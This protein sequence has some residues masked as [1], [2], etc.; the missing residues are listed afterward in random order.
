VSV[1][2]T[3][4]TARRVLIGL[5]HDPRTIALLLVVPS[6]L[7]AI[8]RYTF[9]DTTGLFGR[10][11]P[12]MLGLFPLITMFLVTSIT[13]LRERTS[14]TLERLMTM[15]MGRL[16]LIAGYA[17]AFALCTVAQVALVSTVAAGFLGLHVEGSLAG[18]AALALANAILGVGMGLLV[19]AFATSEFQA[20]QFMPAVVF[21]QLLLCGL[22]APRNGMA[23]LLRWVSDALPLSYAYDAL[24]R[25]AAGTVDRDLGVDIAVTVGAALL[26]VSLAAATIRRRTD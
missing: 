16:D 1:R 9:S 11:A 18:V 15:P 3:S 14:G 7:L 5:R 20:V 8:V 25:A 21:P 19:S 17:V 24:S 2:A 13:M 12:P 10:L 4:A 23:A 26:A 22:F 6:G